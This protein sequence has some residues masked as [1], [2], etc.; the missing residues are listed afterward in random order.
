MNALKMRA[1]ASE[2]QYARERELEFRADVRSKAL[3]AL[4]AA[5]KLGRTDP[6]AYANELV[7]EDILKPGGALLR[8]ERDLNEAGVPVKET[9]LQSRLAG[10]LRQVAHDMSL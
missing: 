9:E 6:D 5:E 7:S 2:N 8:L 1:D 3:I 10:I 4:W